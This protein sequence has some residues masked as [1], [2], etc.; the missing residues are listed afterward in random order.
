[1][2]QQST[3][4]GEIQE[5]E[6]EIVSRVFALGDRK[7]GELMTHRNDLVWI[8]LEDNFSEIKAKVDEEPH[9]V[10]P[11][12]DKNIDNIVGSISLKDLFR[13][14][15]G[16]SDFVI[17]EHLRKPAYLPENMAAYRVLEQFKT[18][19][20]HSAFVVD[21][22]GSLQGIITMDDVMDELIGDSIEASDEYQITQRNS[23]SWLVDG[24]FPYFELMEYFDLPVKA[25]TVAFATVGG[26]FISITHHIPVTGEKVRWLDYE[27]EIVD[28]DGHR[29]DKIMITKL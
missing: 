7:A 18:S 21:E 19:K 6:Q 29:I 23:S 20:V 10:Y 17:S 5:I 9:S 28:M 25:N 24:Q 27:L 4:G 12:C 22:Y 8:D 2:I 15:T 11:V 26:L 13:K 16:V 1:M 14:G 3:I